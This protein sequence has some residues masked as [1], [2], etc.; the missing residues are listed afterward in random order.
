MES[1]SRA[2]DAAAMLGKEPAGKASS[3]GSGSQGPSP[4][5]LRCA[6]SLSLSAALA[7]LLSVVAVVACL[8]L[9]VKTSD[10]QARI[11]ALEAAEGAPSIH[12]LP[13]TLDQ[14]KALVQE[15]VERLLTQVRGW[16]IL[17]VDNVLHRRDSV[18]TLAWL[19]GAASPSHALA[20]AARGRVLT[21]FSLHSLLPESCMATYKGGGKGR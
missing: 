10:L 15:K 14:L 5:R 8:Y 9:G 13:D 11:A 7:A 4:A 17:H 6:P 2:C 16:G 3:R 18:C 19:R 12:L 20:R 21:D 1:R